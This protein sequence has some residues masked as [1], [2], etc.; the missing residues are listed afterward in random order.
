MTESKILKYVYKYACACNVPD[1]MGEEEFEN[2]LIN[3]W[4]SQLNGSS[5][6]H[7][8]YIGDIRS[9]NRCSGLH[10]WISLYEKFRSKELLIDNVVFHH[11][12][13]TD[14]S[15]L[16]TV[17]FQFIDNNKQPLAAHKDSTFLLGFSLEMEFSM[18][19]L[20]ALVGERKTAFK[21]NFKQ[22]SILVQRHVSEVRNISSL[23]FAPAPPSPRRRSAH[24]TAN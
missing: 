9:G 20:G 22:H 15:R 8:A 16:I 2:K 7:H 13:S 12:L 14:D 17:K 21:F 1:C 10:S 24:R 18:F 6:F 23:Y 19:T 4:F 3:I 5:L 11:G